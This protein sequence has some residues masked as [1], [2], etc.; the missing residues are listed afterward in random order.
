MG[1]RM[2]FE[3]TKLPESYVTL[4]TEYVFEDDP[5]Q[6]KDRYG[7]A[8]QKMVPKTTEL[9]GGWLIKVRGKPGHSIR[10]NSLEQ[11][12]ALK[13]IDADAY[14]RMQ[15]GGEIRPRLIDD[16][17]GEEVNEQGIP[18][19]IARELEEGTQMPKEASRNAHG[20]IDT[21][22]DVNS[23]GDDDL[24]GEMPGEEHVA[25]QIEKTE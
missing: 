2:D 9:R 15:D 10:V 18:I 21:D 8:R 1:I 6:R 25:K 3:V 20:G 16:S 14:A 17:T 24:G 23:A 13:L 19:R 5:K 11:A 22:V 7:N 12:L 4:Q